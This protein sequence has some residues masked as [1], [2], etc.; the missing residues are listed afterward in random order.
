MPLPGNL[1]RTFTSFHTSRHSRCGLEDT[2]LMYCWGRNA[3]GHFGNGVPNSFWTDTAVVGAHGRRFKVLSVGGHSHTC[4]VNATDDVVYCFGHDDLNQVGRGSPLPDDTA[5]APTGGEP[6]GK[7][8]TT[9]DNRN[10]LLTLDGQP[11]CWGGG[12]RTPTPVP[13]PEPFTFIAT[14]G[15]QTCAFGESGTL[16]CWGG[17]RKGEAGVG[18]SEWQ[19]P[20]PTPVLSDIRFHAVFPM[21]DATCAVTADGALYC[22]GDFSPRWVSARLGEQ[23]RTPVRVLP[24]VR[25]RS[26]STGVFVFRACGVTT[27][28]R[29]YCWQ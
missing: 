21:S 26:L 29:L 15:G 13:A 11:L 3:S 8:F 23:R 1:G 24:Q 17:N 28:G 14:G 5:V 2:G 12:V 20:A 6:R 16:Y 18:S 10:C 9:A 22:W 7:A 4:G 25:F 27:D 19:I